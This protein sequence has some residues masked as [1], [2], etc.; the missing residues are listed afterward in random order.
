MK[1][2]ID[3]EKARIERVVINKNPKTMR[4]SFFATGLL[5][6]LS[7][8]A[9]VNSLQLAAPAPAAPAADSEAKPPSSSGWV[10]GGSGWETS[11]SGGWE[12]V[13][14][15]GGW[16]ESSSVETEEVVEETSSS[17]EES[18]SSSSS[19]SSESSSSSSSSSESAS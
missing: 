17:V 10:T 4:I 5:A 18:S 14:E 13:T 19:S 11:G 3:I 2:R 16:E 12:T 15:S 1:I 6:L 7:Q 8:D 9:L